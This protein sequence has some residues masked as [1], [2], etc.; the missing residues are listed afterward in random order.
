MPGIPD[1]PSALID[2]GKYSHTILRAIYIAILVISW[3]VLYDRAL[4]IARNERF[5]FSCRGATVFYKTSCLAKYNRGPNVMQTWLYNVSL[6]IPLGIIILGIILLSI[7]LVR[8]KKD[9]DCAVHIHQLYFVTLALQILPHIV[10]SGILL[11]NLGDLNM[12]EHY[13]CMIGNSTFTCIDEK[14]KQKSDINMVCLV[15]TCIFIVFILSE[16]CYYLS[17]WIIKKEERERQEVGSNICKKCYFF[18]KHFSPLP[19]TFSLFFKVLRLS[20]QFLAFAISV[21]CSRG[22]QSVRG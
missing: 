20:I 14:A 6:W 15:F 2:I 3:S 13:D 21:E 4:D 16:L 11:A 9:R 12:E 8:Y 5:T 10:V 7:K 18:V 17:K 1:L 19:G 22:G